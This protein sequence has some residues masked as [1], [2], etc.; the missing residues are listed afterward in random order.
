MALADPEVV[1]VFGLQQ[2]IANQ[3]SLAILDGATLP[4]GPGVVIL[5]TST[6]PSEISTYLRD[7]NFLTASAKKL[8]ELYAERNRILPKFQT[9]Y[10]PY[11]DLL[12][13]TELAELSELL[14]DIRAKVSATT[15]L[16]KLENQ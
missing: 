6:S 7:H 4:D 9:K 16:E 8:G 1:T 11:H 5:N 12:S 2:E 3:R 13:E 10:K 15:A 14:P